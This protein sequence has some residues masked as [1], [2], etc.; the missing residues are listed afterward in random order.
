MKPAN[1]APIYA[2]MYPELAEQARSAGWACAVHG[3]MGRD[4]D[5]I[6]VPWCRDPCAPKVVVEKAC[7]FF[8]IEQVG[9]PVTSYHGR[10]I[11]TVKLKFGE[12]FL[13][14]SFMPTHNAKE[15]GK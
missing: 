15:Q 4:F 8:A 5:L 12:A 14:M 13:D 2:C 11:F 1:Y 7:R 3:T 10:E 6:Y 9:Q